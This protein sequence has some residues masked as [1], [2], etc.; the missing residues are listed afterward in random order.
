MRNIVALGLAVGLAATTFGQNTNHPPSGMQTPGGQQTSPSPV[1]GSESPG[2]GQ[3]DQALAALDAKG[4]QAALSG[5]TT[6]LEENLASD[7]VRIGPDGEMLS[8]DKMISNR[9]SGVTKYTSIDEHDRK[10]QMFG[11]TAVV[12]AIANVK[13]TSNGQALSGTY[14]SSRVWVNQNGAWR[15]VLFTS[16]HVNTPTTARLEAK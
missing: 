16:T 12:T 7:F 3:T 11:N 5:D 8:R 15:Q 1:T 14:R 13:G 9:K 2:T 10:I 4:K 6:F